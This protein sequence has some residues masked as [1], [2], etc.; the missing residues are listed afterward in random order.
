MTLTL[1]GGSRYTA[2]TDA[3]GN[4][5][6][7]DIPIGDY[8]LTPSLTGYVFAPPNRA[9]FLDGLDAVGFNF[10]IISEG[11]TATS[12]HTI[13][14]K[15]DGTL[16]T[17]GNNT[18]GQLGNGTTTNSSVP[19]QLSGLTGIT[20]LAA[21][22][23]YSVCLKNDGTLLA[24]G[25]NA[26]GQLGDGSTTQRTTPVQVPGLSGVIA[27]AAG[28]DHT[29]ALTSD[30]T[31]WAWGNNSNGQ[32]GDAS[33]TQRNSPAQVSNVSSVTAIAAGNGFT[34]ALASNSTVWAWG[35]NAN[36]QLGNGTTTSSAIPVQSIRTG[37]REGDFCGQRPRHGPDQRRYGQDLGE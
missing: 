33:A 17:W 12:T 24:W 25:N 26:F 20:S 11:R 32:L 9:V 19:A 31:V 13:H 29:V 10:S 36:G 4:Y 34:I 21:G 35:N 2:T 18:N 37:G 1:S 14:L 28:Y 5:A 15:D 8:T 22:N 3:S 7:T 23:D 16:W 30:G 6:F 27:I